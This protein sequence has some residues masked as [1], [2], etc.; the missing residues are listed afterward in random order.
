MPIRPLTVLVPL[1][2]LANA[3]AQSTI[4]HF[5]TFH[6]GADRDVSMAIHRGPGDVI[7]VAGHTRSDWL[8]TA[9]AFQ[10]ARVTTPVPP[11]NGDVDAFVARFK[12]NPLG[13][14][15]VVD[16][17]TYLGGSGLELVFDV[18]VDAAGVTTV[19]GLSTS[20][21]FPS[22]AL[23]PSPTLSGG[24]DG[25]I[26]QISANGSQLLTSTFFGGTGDDRVCDVEIDSGGLVV[27]AGVTEPSLVLLPQAV[28]S[29][30]GGTTDAFVARLVSSQPMVVVWS[31]YLGG[32]STEGMRYV[33]WPGFASLW[34][35]NLDRMA[36]TL[37]ANDD[38]VLATV[39][40][41][42]SIQAYTNPPQPH[43]GSSD[44]YLAVINQNTPWLPSRATFFGGASDERPKAIVRHPG[45]GFVFTGGTGSTNLPV[46]PGCYQPTFS[47]VTPNESYVAWLDP[48]S[49]PP[50]LRYCTYFGGPAGEDHFMA[51]AVE[52][53]GVVTVG[54]FSG[55]GSA[56]TTP[57]CLWST[58]GANQYFGLLARFHLA[59]NGTRDLLYSTLL[60]EP[61]G[62]NLRMFVT[63]IALDEMGDAWLCG[64]CGVPL[65]PEVN[66]IQAYAGGA[67]LVLTH[68]PL[69][70]GGVSR[71]MLQFA[72]P[73][74]TTP[75][76]LPLYTGMANA[77][78]MN[79][80]FGFTATNA[81]P[82]W[83][84]VLVLGTPLPGPVQVFN[85]SLLASPD[86]LFLALSD[87][88]GHARLDF[89]LPP[90]P[91]PP[92]WGLAAQWFF[93]TTAACP[94][95]GIFG[96]SE[97]LLL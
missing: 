2:A 29:Y 43:H 73:A 57:R 31:V 23:F 37:D 38:P 92:N 77:P 10:T 19:V 51:V 91:P 97:R 17:F 4:P 62:G 40:A 12:P 35:G 56:P 79:N 84:G 42:G 63:G 69:L 5:S 28:N 68:M 24:S 21:D 50:S 61:V 44:V 9:G 66:R 78:V 58:G 59:G 14:G 39:S 33:D 11:T 75:A 7:T 81:P 25:F 96:A 60:S 6:G 20:A 76:P 80:W 64:L 15:H 93:F 36:L 47:G 94:G 89:T 45:G 65:Y 85:V 87:P 8:A 34:E 18:D 95:S 3:V 16:W 52:S 74:C 53:S 41:L 83:I 88:Q 46:T 54:G 13:A 1:L 55:D 70:P 71:D 67:D 90:G 26:A 22:P 27:I 32:N 48:F 30:N 49:S 82:N 86:L 72:T